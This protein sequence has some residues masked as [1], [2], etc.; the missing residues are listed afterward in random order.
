MNA[1]T[2]AHHGTGGSSGYVRNFGASMCQRRMNEPTSNGLQLRTTHGS[3]FFFP[4]ILAKLFSAKD[5]GEI[6]KSKSV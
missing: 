5:F 1:F 2:F 3:C 4:N 6:V